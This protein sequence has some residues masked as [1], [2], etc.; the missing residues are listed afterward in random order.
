[1]K[2]RAHIFV[3]GRVHGVC[4]RADTQQIAREIGLTG[5]VKNLLNGKVEIVVEGEKEKVKQMVDWVKHGPPAAKVNNIDIQWQEYI[6]EFK[7]F[8]VS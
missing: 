3:S 1:M 8:Y 7:N 2:I 6:G 5:W 4:F